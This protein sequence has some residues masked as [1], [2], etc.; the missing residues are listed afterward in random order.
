MTLETCP[1]CDH[2]WRDHV[3]ESAVEGDLWGIYHCP[4]CDC[5]GSW[6]AAR[7]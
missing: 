1:R 2:P 4:E 5:T 3:L 7:R 6:S